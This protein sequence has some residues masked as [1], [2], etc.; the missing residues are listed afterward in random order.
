MDKQIR[1]ARFAATA[2]LLKRYVERGDVAGAAAY[3]AQNGKTLHRQYE[4]YADI[5]AGKKIADDTIYR[6]FSMSKVITSVAVMQLYERGLFK[7][8]DPVENFLPGFKN[9]QVF[10]EVEPGKFETVPAERPVV[11]RDLFTMTSGIPYPGDGSPAARTYADRIQRMEAISGDGR[12]FGA[13]ELMNLIG[14]A[15]LDFHPGTQ[16]EY[17]FSIDVLGAVLE[18]ISG[19]SLGEYLRCNVTGPLGMCDT[20]FYLTPEQLPRL[21]KLYHSEGGRLSEAAEDESFLISAALEKPTFESGGGGLFSTLEDYGRFAQMLLGGGTLDGVRILGRKTVDLM[22]TNHLTPRQR[23]TDNW[24]SQ[25]GYGYGLGVRVRMENEVAGSNGS[26]GEWGWD[27]MAG[28]WFCVDPVENMIALF[29]VQRVP[30]DHGN[31]VP[32]YMATVYSAL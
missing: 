26:I 18:V 3:V 8:Y 24:N 23:V 29:L 25:R 2:D 10:K 14:L 11:M 9:Q 32:P 28:T 7:M 5:E 16:W 12:L 27:G 4:G 22:R 20:G 21:S 6:I 30:G 31:L 15:P 19:K 13:V 17:G 1:T